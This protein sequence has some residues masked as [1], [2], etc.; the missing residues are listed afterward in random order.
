MSTSLSS[1]TRLALIVTAA[2][3]FVFALVDLFLPSLIHD[4]LWPAPF[5]R[6]PDLWL[7][8]DGLFT[9][10][11]AVGAVYVLRVNTWPVARLY[12]LICA[13]W[14]ALDLV[15]SLVTVLA[16]SGAPATIW[17]YIVL[18]VLYLGLVGYSWRQ[19]ET[20]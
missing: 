2:S 9:I 4:T 3:L 6:Q 15:L 12:L 10:A 20:A 5:E 19:Q 8:Y 11:M 13:V 14:V 18:A 7:R 17:L 16:A 1:A